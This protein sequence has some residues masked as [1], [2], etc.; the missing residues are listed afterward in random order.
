MKSNV[1]LLVLS[2]VSLSACATPGDIV[3]NDE[4]AIPFVSS[5]GITEW[6]PASDDALYIKAI[7]G[8]WYYVRTMGRCSRIEGATSL[9]FLTRGPDQLDRHGA[10]NVD[11]QHCPL[12]SVVK[13]APPP[14]KAKG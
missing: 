6:Q 10:I 7:N 12:S 13:S 8:D 2:A 11:G 1:F 3:S 5:N 14:A 4:S 9:A